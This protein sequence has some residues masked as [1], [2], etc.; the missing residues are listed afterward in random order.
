[1]VSF[2]LKSKAINHAS[3]S[4]SFFCMIKTN[5]QR[6]L[7]LLLESLTLGIRKPDDV[8]T[9]SHLL[10]GNKIPISLVGLAVKKLIHLFLSLLKCCGTR[11]LWRKPTCWL[12][13]RNIAQLPFK[14]WI[15]HVVSMLSSIIITRN[16][17]N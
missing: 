16:L 1:M 14:I 15:T 4:Y 9:C 8:T 3:P 6:M 11:P 13:T 2:H 5:V 7:F 17:A 10:F 12:E